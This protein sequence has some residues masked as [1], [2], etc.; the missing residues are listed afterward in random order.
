M[1]LAFS[2]WVLDVDI[3]VTI[4]RSAEELRDHC[5]CGYCRNFY[6]AVDASYP[7]LRPFLAQ[8]GIDV[9]APDELMP[10]TPTWYRAVY[11]VC[12]RILQQGGVV[13][14]SDGLVIDF[15]TAEQCDVHTAMPQPN[16]FITVEDISLPWVLD[17]P[18][19]DVESAANDP[20][21]VQKIFDTMLRRDSNDITFS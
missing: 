20:S 13:P 21:F 18:A 1:I 7:D 2:D 8:F 16:F 11:P 19:E 12:G 10:Y 15:Q 5:M 17:E 6:A 14:V 4:E 3:T 9:E